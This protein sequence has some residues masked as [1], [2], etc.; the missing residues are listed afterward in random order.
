[1]GGRD[2]NMAAFK[3]GVK[4]ITLL[5]SAGSGDGPVYEFPLYKKFAPLLDPLI[6]EVGR[7]RASMKFGGAA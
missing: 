2:E 1:M 4:G 5:F 3:P 6:E 7:L